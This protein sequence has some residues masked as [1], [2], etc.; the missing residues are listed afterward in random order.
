MSKK[1]IV[2]IA[3]IG[4]GIALGIFLIIRERNSQGGIS[5]NDEAKETPAPEL[6]KIPIPQNQ[7]A[8]ADGE[9]KFPIELQINFSQ[10]QLPT[11]LPIYKNANVPYTEKD[12]Q[13]IAS[14]LGF[15]SK[16]VKFSNPQEG[17]MYLYSGS[18]S[19]LRV[20][21]DPQIVIYSASSALEPIEK[22]YSEGEV[23]QKARAFLTDNGIIKENFD[24]KLKKITYKEIEETGHTEGKGT[25]TIITATFNGTLDG[26]DFIGADPKYELASVDL[27]K[28]LKVISL[29]V[30]NPGSIEKLDEYPVK[31]EKEIQ[32]TI[33]KATLQSLDNG[34]IEALGF[35]VKLIR[36][37]VIRNINVI[38]VQEQTSKQEFLQP[39]FALTGSAT[40]TTGPTVP[41]LLYLPAISEVYLE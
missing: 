18:E 8:Y 9:G 32:E 22:K 33:S 2:I 31:K 26:F 5:Q 38:Y 13:T 11:M 16:V 30:D 40:L 21:A 25:P 12:A 23:E 20:V 7:A 34:N 36:R 35:S 19:S 3:I 10:T 28:D 4:I 27:D 29:H 17:Q 24:T 37:V 41:V 14:K 1:R 15:T 39:S 6:T